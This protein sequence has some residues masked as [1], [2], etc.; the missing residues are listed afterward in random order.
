V[1]TR[2]LLAFDMGRQEG[3]E[4]GRRGG[5]TGAMSEVTTT[6]SHSSVPLIALLCVGVVQW[7][8]G[9][10]CARALHLTWAGKETGEGL[11]HGDMIIGRLQR[12]ATHLGLAGR[13]RW[14]E[15]CLLGCR[16]CVWRSIKGA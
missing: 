16:L 15:A 8:S 11:G 5:G 6:S 12:A 13:R 14:A 1:R 9:G 2:A 4:G 3:K 7:V 10:V